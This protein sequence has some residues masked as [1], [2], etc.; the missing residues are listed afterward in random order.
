LKKLKSEVSAL[1]RKIQLTLTPKQEKQPEEE[2]TNQNLNPTE[3]MMGRNM[4]VLD[5]RRT[6]HV[7]IG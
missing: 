6:L 5:G 1:E 3:V 7:H 4:D 2:N